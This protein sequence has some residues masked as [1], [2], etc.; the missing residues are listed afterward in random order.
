MQ[1]KIGARRIAVVKVGGDVLLSDVE[2]T[3]LG[4]NIRDLR[5]LGFSVVVLH[6]GGPQATR[7]QER[8][9]MTA[10]KVAGQRVT[11]PDDLVVV[12]QAVCGEVNVA[13]T[14]V[15]LGAGV[16]AFG[17]HGASGS[18]VQAVKRPARKVVGGGD[19]PIDYGE[20]GDVVAIRTELLTGLLDLDVVPVIATLGVE[21]DTGRP[22]NINADTTATEVA[23]A[24]SAELLLLVTAVGGVF[25]DVLDETT[26]YTTVTTSVARALIRDGVIVGGMIPK[27]EEALAVIEAGVG[28]V[29]ILG[30]GQP[31]AFLAAAR[32]DGSLGTRICSDVA[33]P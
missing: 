23:R 9:G 26:R 14:C 7:L 19:L 4:P 30:A 21:V 25:R 11:S 22:F 28:A 15:L 29:A 20:V 24:L 33:T 17:C 1:K 8:L 5:A 31:G 27:V 18:L 32:G 12:A 2:R 13:L 6:G 16:P 3:G 10:V